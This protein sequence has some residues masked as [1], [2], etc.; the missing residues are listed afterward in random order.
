[1]GRKKRKAMKPWCWYCNRDFEDEKV[2]V[3]HQKAKHFK[4]H[5]CNKK[6][7]TGPGLAIHCMQVHKETID[8]IP[9]SLPNRGSTD[10]EVYGMEGI[11]EEDMIAHEISKNGG[12][13]SSKVL[14]H[15]IPIPPPMMPM[16]MPPMGMHP[17]HQMHMNMR[18]M[19]PPM[20]M[21]PPPGFPMPPMMPPMGM[22]GRPNIPMP[23]MPQP[24]S[25]APSFS[26]HGSDAEEP[27]SSGQGTGPAHVTFPAYSAP[28]PDPNEQNNA[29]G[30]HVPPVAAVPIVPATGTGTKIMHPDSDISLEELRSMLPKYQQRRSAPQNSDYEGNSGYNMY[31]TQGQAQRYGGQY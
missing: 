1:V 3:Q 7:F 16:G 24:P 26:N 23:P 19:M 11:P 18:G 13:P 14:K 5:I 10:V 9:H 15:D 12:E 2:L 22:G 29:P 28:L 31:Q 25:A 8:Q 21:R 6:L 20:G 30:S 17:M 4:C 27:S